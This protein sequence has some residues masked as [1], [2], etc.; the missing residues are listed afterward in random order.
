MKIMEGIDNAVYSTSSVNTADA[1]T[2]VQIL[3]P[4]AFAIAF[5]A[6]L[7]SL[8]AGVCGSILASLIATFAWLITTVVLIT[9]FVCWGIVKDKV[10]GDGSGSHAAFGTGMWTELA[11]MIALL[12]GAFVVLVSCCGSRR[13]KSRGSNRSAGERPVYSGSGNRGRFW[14]RKY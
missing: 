11:A 10:N 12:F 4:I 14:Q 2:R 8:G 9:D 3:H 5:I 1:L 7:F 6:F 13:R